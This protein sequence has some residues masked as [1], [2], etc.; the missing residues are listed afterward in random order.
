MQMDLSQPAAAV[1]CPLGSSQAL[2]HVELA[3]HYQ[4][5]ALQHCAA[6]FELGQL[7]AGD[8][9]VLVQLILGLETAVQAY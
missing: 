3:P 8:Y 6:V 2:A 7:T 5:L 9:Q 1:S 4:E